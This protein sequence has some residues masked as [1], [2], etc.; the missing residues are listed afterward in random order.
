MKRFAEI[1][2]A[3]GASALLCGTA[4]AHDMPDPV[5]NRS[6]DM[7]AKY[8]DIKVAKAEGY[9]QLFECTTHD[10]HGTLGFIS[11]IPAAPATAGW[12][13]ANPTC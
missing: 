9:Q 7:A 12:C 11:S 4:V 3:V 6:R 2:L 8:L 5:L 13:S 10:E 1:V